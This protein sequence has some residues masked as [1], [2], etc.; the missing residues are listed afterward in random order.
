MKNTLS[1]AVLIILAT[2]GAAQA[3]SAPCFE[4]QTPEGT[5]CSLKYKNLGGPSWLAYDDNCDRGEIFD[6]LAIFDL[7]NLVRQSPSQEKFKLVSG[8]KNTTAILDIKMD[9]EGYPTRYEYRYWAETSLIFPNGRA[10]RDV[11][12]ENLV[13]RY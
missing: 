13:R 2:T 1:I 7:A 6:S 8:S 9:R 10:D 3:N 5:A 12:C 11:S 4:G